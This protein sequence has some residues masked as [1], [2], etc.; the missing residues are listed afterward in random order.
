M[1]ADRSII[2][3]FLTLFLIIAVPIGLY[4]RKLPT[5]VR[6]S[7]EIEL[8]KFSSQPVSM[9]F[10]QPP[11]V[12]SG[13]V[14]PV[15]PRRMTLS[16]PPPAKVV[17]AAATPLTV[18]SQPRSLGSSLPVVSVISYDGSTRTAIVGDR[19][20]IEGSELDGGTIVKIE[21]SRVLMRKNGKNIWL[22]IE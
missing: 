19:V 17:K 10:P 9:S 2:A 7:A 3:K 18:K 22:T 11:V 1:T 15:T 20:V 6:P 21:E 12:F 13:L 16:Q 14:C 8:T 4:F 5:S